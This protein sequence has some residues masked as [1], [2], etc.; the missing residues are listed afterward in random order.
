MVFHKQNL[1][2]GKLTVHVFQ[3]SCGFARDGFR[4]VLID[5]S[6]PGWHI[7]QYLLAVQCQLAAKFLAA[8]SVEK[9]RV[10]R[11]AFVQNGRVA[12]VFQHIRTDH[13]FFHVIVRIYQ[14]ITENQ[15]ALDVAHVVDFVFHIA[16]HVF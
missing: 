3:K 16:P 10:A 14:I 1:M 7:D 6:A 9:H 8:G 4:I 12:E 13:L 5:T 2:I 11:I 15:V